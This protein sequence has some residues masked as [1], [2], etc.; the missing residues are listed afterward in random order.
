MTSYYPHPTA[1]ELS[2]FL[3]ARRLLT[4]PWCQG[5]DVTWRHL[6]SFPR[7]S[8]HK[9]KHAYT[10]V[11]EHRIHFDN[12]HTPHTPVF[13]YFSGI[14]A[15]CPAVWL[16]QRS[17]CFVYGQWHAQALWGL[18]ECEHCQKRLEPCVFAC[19]RVCLLADWWGDTSTDW[20]FRCDECHCWA[21]SCPLGSASNTAWPLPSELT[22]SA[23]WPDYGPFC[24]LVPVSHT[25]WLAHAKSRNSISRRVPNRLLFWTIN[26]FF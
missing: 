19:M 3:L 16:L 11:Y 22:L 1:C 13:W 10:H 8:A 21:S 7:S 4:L 9:H 26:K 23:H 5:N 15:L 14:H 2:L 17:V 20:G 25:L 18:T 12:T 24:L 6:F